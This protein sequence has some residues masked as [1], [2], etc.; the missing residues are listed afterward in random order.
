MVFLDDDLMAIKAD[1]NRCWPYDYK[2]RCCW[3]WPQGYMVRCF[4]MANS[5]PEKHADV[6]RCW[7]YCYKFRCCWRFMVKHK[8]LWIL[9]SWLQCQIW[10][11]GN[12]EA[13]VVWWSWEHDTDLL[14]SQSGTPDCEGKRLDGDLVV[15][16]PCIFLIL[17]L[18]F[19]KHMWNSLL[20]AWSQKRLGRKNLLSRLRLHNDGALAYNFWKCKWNKMPWIELKRARLGNVNYSF[21]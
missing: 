9:T 19:V 5:W 10:L 1:I 17:T 16:R 4:W 6:N 15:K 21:K 11:D 20:T 18:W 7:P 8:N 2:V 14:P 13:G 3:L 12:L